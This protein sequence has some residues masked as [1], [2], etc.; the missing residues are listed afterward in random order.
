MAAR[1]LWMDRIDEYFDRWLNSAFDAPAPPYFDAPAPPS[2]IPALP[3]LVHSK[4]ELV[5]NER[6]DCD[7]PSEFPAHWK[8]WFTRR[9]SSPIPKTKPP[10]ALKIKRPGQ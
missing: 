2:R 5:L 7:C 4:L 6:T 10:I 8:K 9:H 1:E 3:E